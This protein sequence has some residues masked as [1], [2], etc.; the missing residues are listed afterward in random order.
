MGQKQSTPRSTSRLLD[1]LNELFSEIETKSG[2][3]LCANK[4]VHHKK[5]VH[6]DKPLL[7]IYKDILEELNDDTTFTKPQRSESQS[8]WTGIK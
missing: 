6:P 7:W 1:K 8:N 4:L 3:I 5:L 2:S